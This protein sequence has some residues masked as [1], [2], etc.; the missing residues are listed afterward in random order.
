MRLR[1][2]LQRVA[3]ADDA[4]VERVG[5]LQHGL[6]LVLHHAADRDAGPVA[7]PRGRPPASSTLGRISGDSPCSS[8]SF[9][10]SVVQLGEQRRRA[11]SARRL[12]AARRAA[13]FCA[14]PAFQ[15]AAGAF[16]RLAAAAQLARAARGARRPAPSRRSSAASSVA[17][18]LASR[19]PASRRRRVCALADVDADGL[20]AADDR[21]ARSRAPRCGGGSPRP[22][23]ASRAG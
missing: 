9:A 4:L 8:A 12:G 21:R 17:E 6:D 20:L 5:E 18:P 16:D 23:P 7:R 1:D 19:A 14:P 13:A 11:R 15:R 3:L 10:C 22:R 2:H